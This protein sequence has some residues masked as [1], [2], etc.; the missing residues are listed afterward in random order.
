[1]AVFRSIVGKNAMV[2]DTHELIYVH[3]VSKQTLDVIPDGLSC[4]K[5]RCREIHISFLDKLDVRLIALCLSTVSGNE[6]DHLFAET[7]SPA[8]IKLNASCNFRVSQP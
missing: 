4:V 5:L 1:M 6:I 3:C 2:F 7:S 8:L